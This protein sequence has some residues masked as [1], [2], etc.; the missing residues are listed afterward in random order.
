MSNFLYK[1][2]QLWNN[3]RQFGGIHDLDTSISSFKSSLKNCLLKVQNKYD[4][5]E[6]CEK[7]FETFS[8]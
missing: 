8:E 3:Y 6:W 1:S 5:H 7:N 4:P 2:H